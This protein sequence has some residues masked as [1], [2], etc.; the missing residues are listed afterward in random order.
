MSQKFSPPWW[1][2]NPHV[3]T[4][5]PVLTKVDRPH[6]SRE[7]L[8]LDDGDFIDLD[9]Q[10]SPQDNQAIL[11]IIHGLEGSAESH[12]AR[13]ILAACKAVNICAVVHHHRSCSG[14]LNR[15]VRGYHSGDTQDIQT[16]LQHLKK[17]Y[18]NSKLLAVG[19]SLGG[20]VLV[21]YQGEQQ[22][23]SLV[24]R[25]VAISAPL[26][27]AACAKRLEK[28]FSKL[29][30]SYLIKQ[31]QEK[32]RNKVSNPELATLMPINHSDI[33]H[34]NTFYAFDDRVT[35]PLHGFD[36]VD[37]YYARASGLP[38]L[39]QITKP[40]L[41]IHAKDDPFMTTAVIPSDAQLSNQVE[42][43]LHDN[44]GHV[45]FINGGSPWRPQYYL[46]QRVLNFLTS[47][48]ASVC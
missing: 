15:L 42:Y 33:E 47:S 6:L 11:V 27:L 18:S 19:Y 2:K 8:E 5:L 24:E 36:D 39:N 41:V 37:D 29:Y 7:R 48:E 30:Q 35:A 13:R 23:N 38:Y 25:A 40:T 9:W 28:G 17:Q 12:Y 10:G 32:M 34:L 16:T 46:E 22:Q 45:G 31:L 14:V 21:K 44:G 43:E 1:A 4:I 26:H 20:N 3:Q